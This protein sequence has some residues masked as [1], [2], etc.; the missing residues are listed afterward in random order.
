[1]KYPKA[2]SRI[3]QGV[4][5][6]IGGNCGMSASPVSDDPERKEELRAY[7]GDLSYEWNGIG[8]FLVRSAHA[9]PA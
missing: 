5:T 8:E 7:I 4:T 3:L 2:E 9:I 6:E 1:M